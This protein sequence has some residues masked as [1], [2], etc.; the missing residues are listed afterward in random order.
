[1]TETRAAFDAL[2]RQ[3]DQPPAPG[4][5]RFWLRLSGHLE[6]PPSAPFFYWQSGETMWAIIRPS[7]QK[8][9]DAGEIDRDRLLSMA[10]DDDVVSD[11][12]MVYR[13][14]YCALI[15]AADEGSAWATMRAAFAEMVNVEQDFC[16][17]DPMT[18]SQLAGTGRFAMPTW[19]EDPA[20]RP[21]TKAETLRELA[22][23]ILA[24]VPLGAEERRLAAEIIDEARMRLVFE[25]ARAT[26]DDAASA[27]EPA[28]NGALPGTI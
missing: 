15:D 22:R 6:T 18:L 23:H 16:V 10:D 14:T 20:G 7:L 19:R 21:A 17:A 4:L 2:I 26:P 5:T 28:Q 3:Y 8:Q 11:S 12:V 13:G 27:T 25:A 1:M 24:G 9:I